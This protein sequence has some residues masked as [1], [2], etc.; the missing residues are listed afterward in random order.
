MNNQVSFS[1]CNM[2]A[3]EIKIITGS[4]GWKQLNASFITNWK[5]Y[6]QEA[7]GL[8]IFMISACLF[9]SLLEAKHSSVHLAI[10]G[11]MTRT[12]LMGLMMGLTALFI[13]YWPITASSGSHI[14]PAVTLSFFRL[15]KLC[16]WDALFYILF[17]FF[18]GTIAVIIMKALLGDLL[19]AE[20]VHFVVT[21]PVNGSLWAAVV[22]EFLIAFITMTIVLFSSHHTKLKKF[23]RI[24]AGLLVFSWV[25]LAGPVS[26]F[27]M[28][29]ARSFASAFPAHHWN[30]FWIYA[31]IPVVGM[32]MATEVFLFIRRNHDR[33]FRHKA[34]MT[35]NL[36][37][38]TAGPLEFVL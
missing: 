24:F 30:H 27:G 38:K 34:T 32:L 21:V 33:R 26:G 14:N 5:Y 4:R 20:P 2:R 3:I 25:I 11:M 6:L 35:T 29:P 16:H 1:F 8:A 18:G 17:Q 22:T 15:G 12:V 7:L 13:F 10:P 36:R 9:G 31:I 19:T 37:N 28:N 23:T